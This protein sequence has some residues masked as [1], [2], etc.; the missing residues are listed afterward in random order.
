MTTATAA[1]FQ[2]RAKQAET[3]LELVRER[4]RLLWEAL[5]TARQYNATADEQV[6]SLRRELKEVD[7]EKTAALNEIEVLRDGVRSI[8]HGEH[9]GRAFA[10]ELLCRR[11]L[12]QEPTP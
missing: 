1:H 2:S 7:A 4:N 12:Q 3:V 11:T 8:A 6:A 9:S 5:K 10:N